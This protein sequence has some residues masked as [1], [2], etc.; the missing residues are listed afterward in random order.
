[1][2]LGLWLLAVALWQSAEYARIFA[3][4]GIM[5]A[6]MCVVRAAS[7][8]LGFTV[9]L[10]PWPVGPAINAVWIALLAALMLRKAGRIAQAPDAPTRT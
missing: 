4:F 1:M 5:S 2:G 6:S 9:P 8:V 7:D 3:V 10:P